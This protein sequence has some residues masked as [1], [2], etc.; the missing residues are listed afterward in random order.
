MPFLQQIHQR[1]LWVLLFHFFLKNYLF[2]SCWW[3]F[4]CWW[5]SKKCLD[6]E[7]TQNTEHTSW[8]S[9]LDKPKPSQHPPSHSDHGTL[10]LHYAA[11]GT[12]FFLLS[13]STSHFILLLHSVV[14][15]LLFALVLPYSTAMLS[16]LLICTILT[17]YCPVYFLHS[18][19][20]A[21]YLHFVLV[22]VHVLLCTVLLCYVFQHGSGPLW[23][24][25]G[26]PKR[27]RNLKLERE[28]GWSMNYTI[29]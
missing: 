27:G 21:M 9:H 14:Y 16:C 19:H 23:G 3:V 6:A 10:A 13:F 29:W 8:N 18:A 1:G 22:F 15:R 2:F 17:I 24:L 4:F 7:H 28:H 20:T 25:W 11:R 12:I 5:V 26:D